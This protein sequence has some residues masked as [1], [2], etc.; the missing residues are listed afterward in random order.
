MHSIVTARTHVVS[1]TTRFTNEKTTFSFGP[2][3]YTHS[4]PHQLI[5]NL[6][7][8]TGGF[9]LL[10]QDLAGF[11]TGVQKGRTSPQKDQRAPWRR[12]AFKEGGAVTDHRQEQEEGEAEE[13][14]GGRGSARRGVAQVLP[15]QTETSS[16]KGYFKRA[17]PTRF[18]RHAISFYAKS[19]KVTNFMYFNYVLI[20]FTL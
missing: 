9:F 19:K 16:K 6:S 18:S 11:I 10:R 14:R 4:R 1:R 13:G 20:F 7:A 12:L 2:Q 17:S 5:G 3:Q 15:T 8:Q